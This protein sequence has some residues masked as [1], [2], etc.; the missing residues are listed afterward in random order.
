MPR[1]LVERSFPGGLAISLDRAGAAVWRGVIARSTPL[2]VT[3]VHSYVTQ[4]RK[5]A[6]CVYVSP[7][8]E[9]LR[10]AAEQ[11]DLPVDRINEVRVLDPYLYREGDDR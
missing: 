7:D 6:F 1:F 5:K 4:D 2:G 10:E 9:T 11:C 8:A 3:W